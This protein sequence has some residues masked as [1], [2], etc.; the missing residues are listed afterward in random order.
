MPATQAVRHVGERARL[1]VGPQLAGSRLADRARPG[2][3]RASRDGLDRRVHAPST[4]RTAARISA[5]SGSG[6]VERRDHRQDRGRRAS[7]PAP[8]R[9]ARAGRAVRGGC[10]SGPERHAPDLVEEPAE[11]DDEAARNTAMTASVRTDEPGLQDRH[12]AA[13]E[14]EGRRSRHHQRGEQQEAA[15][16]GRAA[17]RASADLVEVRGAVQLGER[18]GREERDRLGERVV[19][20]VQERAERRRLPAQP[21]AR[22]P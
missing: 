1:D 6:Q 13:E 16:D 8:G 15:R 12:L 18:P 11:E 10:V 5:R 17:E 21:E 20:H 9:A 7:C 22:P 3:A 19:G 4:T 14:A 2:I